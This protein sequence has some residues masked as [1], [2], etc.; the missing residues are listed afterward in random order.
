M[1]SEGG[2]WL[3]PIPCC[4]REYRSVAHLQTARQSALAECLGSSQSTR[5]AEVGVT[6]PGLQQVDTHTP[7][8]ASL[9]S[10]PLQRHSSFIRAVCVDAHVRIRPGGRSVMSVPTGTAECR[11]MI[12]EGCWNAARQLG[13]NLELCTII[14]QR[15]F[16]TEI[17]PCEQ[18]KAIQA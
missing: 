12:R 18:E 1:A 7:N 6:D 15:S 3:L 9:P 10:R 17:C 14:S 4:S 2:H 5:Q 13:S 16:Q 8:P 11:V